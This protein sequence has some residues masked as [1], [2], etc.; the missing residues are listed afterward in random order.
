MEADDIETPDDITGVNHA[1]TLLG[2][3][4]N[5]GDDAIDAAFERFVAD[6]DSGDGDGEHYWAAVKAREVARSEG[7]PDG[8][9]VYNVLRTDPRPADLGSLR[10]AACLLACP[11]LPTDSRRRNSALRAVR[12]TVE[13]V[14]ERR[15]EL[16]SA[17]RAISDANMDAVDVAFH[18]LRCNDLREGKRWVLGPDFERRS[19][20][21]GDDWTYGVASD[22]VT[23]RYVAPDGETALTIVTANASDGPATGCELIRR[24]DGETVE[25][26]SG[27]Y[28]EMHRLAKR[29]ILEHDAS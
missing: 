19:E 17:D 4:R 2:V 5:A 14:R 3:D 27:R 29:W 10:D 15:S 22:G 9:A 20:P 11:S 21:T 25:T 13:T 8:T 26:R 28:G 24:R 12:R 23:E 1:N 6:I 7:V 18:A 16:E